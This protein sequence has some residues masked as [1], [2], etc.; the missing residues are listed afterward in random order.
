MA[1][2]RS[3][4][5]QLTM[6]DAFNNQS[7]RICTTKNKIRKIKPRVQN[8]VLIS[9]LISYNDCML[10]WQPD[11]FR[12][13]LVCSLSSIQA[14]WLVD[15]CLQKCMATYGRTRGPLWLHVVGSTFFH[16][17]HTNSSI[18]NTVQAY[19]HKE[20]STSNQYFQVTGRMGATYRSSKLLSQKQYNPLITQCNPLTTQRS[21][22]TTQCNPLTTQCNPLTTQCNPLTTQCIHL[23]T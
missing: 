4:F 5:T 6:I 13:W 16:L 23:K 7:C 18:H 15:C 8:C 19:R 14:G 9:L 3:K 17:Q 22:L 11:S 20:I 12:G 10:D 2:G 21:P 1:I